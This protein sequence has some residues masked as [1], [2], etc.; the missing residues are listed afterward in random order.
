MLLRYHIYVTHQLQ[1][2]FHRYEQC[3]MTTLSTIMR[4]HIDWNQHARISLVKIDVE[5]AEWLVLQGII[6]LLTVLHMHA[7]MVG[8]GMVCRVE[9]RGFRSHRPICDGST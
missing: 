2:P 9:S 7:M 1:R 4:T 6:P 3:H 5:G 8:Y